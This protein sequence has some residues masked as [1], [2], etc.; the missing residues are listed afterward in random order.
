MKRLIIIIA[1]FLSWYSMNAQKDIF[2]PAPTERLN[3]DVSYYEETTYNIWTLRLFSGPDQKGEQTTQTIKRPQSITCHRFDSLGRETVITRYVQRN[4]SVGSIGRDSLGNVDF[5]ANEISRITPDTRTVMS[6][7]GQGRL[8]TTKTWSFNL[9]DSTLT[10]SDSCLYDSTG[11]LY[12]MQILRD[13]LP[14]PNNYQRQD[15]NGSYTISYQDGTYQQYRFD[16]EHCLVRYRDREGKTVRYYYNERCN[17]IRQVS[18]WEN[19]STLNMI[20][21]DYEYDDYGNWTRCSQNEKDPGMPS[22]SLKI[23]ERTYNYR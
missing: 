1:A 4:A 9:A 16:S 2:T 13:S 15:R 22:R 12:G 5:I 19:G 14:V 6:Y 17:I 3:G 11:V 23:I 7:D 8:C 20:F 10:Q 21:D 18:E